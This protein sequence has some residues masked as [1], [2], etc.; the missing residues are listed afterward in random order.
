[1]RALTGLGFYDE[2]DAYLSWLLHATGLTWSELR[3]LY[4][5]Y[6]RSPPQRDCPQF[7]G[8]RGSKPVHTGNAARFQKQL[9]VYGQVALAAYAFL[10]D[11][12]EIDPT[13]KRRLP[14][15]GSALPRSGPFS[16]T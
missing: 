9:D 12:R 13:A 5:V 3:V 14:G 1:M 10:I 16:A 4:D 2:A 8:Y 7:A 15:L 6:G 11:G